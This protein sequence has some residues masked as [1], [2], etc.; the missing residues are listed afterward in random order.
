MELDRYSQSFQEL[1]NKHQEYIRVADKRAITVL[2]KMLKYAQEIDDPNL[3]GYVY[4]SLAFAEHFIMG[5]YSRFMKYLNLSANSLFRCDDQGQLMHVYYLIAIDAM[6]KGMFDISHHYY[7]EARAIAKK[8]GMESSSAILDLSIAHILMRIGYYEESRVYTKSC[9]KDLKKDKEHPHYYS[10]LMGCYMNDIIISLELEELDKARKTMNIVEKFMGKH[11]DDL[12]SGTRLNYYLIRARLDAM[13]GNCNKASDEMEALIQEMHN[14]TNI[15]SFVDDVV[16]LCKAMI[17]NKRYPCA[18]RIIDEIDMNRIAQDATEP[19]RLLAEVKIDYYKAIGDTDELEKAYMEQD[20]AL[21]LQLEKRKDV[22]QRVTDLAR[23]TGDIRK[24]RSHALDEKERF[25]QIAKVDELTKIP[26]RYGAT[27]YLDVAFEK[28]YK[29][30]TRLGV[31]YADLDDLK[32]INDTK[33]HL[34]GDACLIDMGRTL[35]KHM[36]KG[37]FFA[38]RYGGDEFILIYEKATT[39]EIVDSITQLKREAS[40]NFSFGIH[41]GIPRDRQKS[42]QYLDMADKSLYEDKKKK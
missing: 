7:L 40:V 17:K 31:V 39:K 32:F 3:I 6:N 37:E 30:G 5:R 38:A 26:N 25:L 33:G 18:K 41:N 2:N 4:H 11:H 21:A 36:E 9:I 12:R 22:Y 27:A 10:N 16:K 28:A 13:E 19:L 29:N 14:T 42:W 35:A 23:L 8:T 24:A 15:H 1:Y 20:K 34:A